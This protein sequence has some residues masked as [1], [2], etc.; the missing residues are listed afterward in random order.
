MNPSIAAWIDDLQSTDR[1]VTTEAFLQLQRETG[2]P[3]DWA[4]EVWDALRNDIGHEDNHRRAIAA[5]LLCNLAKSDPEKRILDVLPELLELTKDKKFVTARHCLLAL[6]RIGLAG[7]EQKGALLAGLA[8]RYRGCMDEKNGT[9]IRFDIVESLR[10][11]YDAEPD[12]GVRQ[13]ALDLIDRE[14]IPKY[15]K[16]YASAW[17]G[18]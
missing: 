2:E 9:L 1:S 16:K 5:Q 10:K 15:R 7:P 3:V 4:Y 13:L 8:N 11:L 17:K 6:W 12:A 18:V 14:D